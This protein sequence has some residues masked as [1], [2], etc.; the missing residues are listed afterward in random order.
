MDTLKQV[1][2]HQILLSLGQIVLL[3][4][5]VESEHIEKEILPFESRFT[6]LSPQKSRHNCRSLNLTVRGGGLAG[7]SGLDSP[8]EYNKKRLVD[9]LENG[10]RR[11]NTCF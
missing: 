1:Q 7:D 8:P 10:F 6:A 3:K 4:K 2:L 11:R 9:F 5:Y